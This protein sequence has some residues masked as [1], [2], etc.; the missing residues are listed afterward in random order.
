MDR[1][2]DGSDH[3]AGDRHLGRLEGDAADVA[4]DVG[5]DL[6]ELELEADQRSVGHDPGQLDAV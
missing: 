5:A 3:A 6:D 2:Q 4:H 1:R